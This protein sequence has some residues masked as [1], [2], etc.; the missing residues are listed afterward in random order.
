MEELISLCCAACIAGGFGDP[1]AVP[2]EEPGL[3]WHGL[4]ASTLTFR[5]EAPES[6]APAD[7]FHLQEARLGLA[8]APMRGVG[9]YTSIAA[10]QGGLG[11]IEAY[12][13]LKPLK[14]FG[15]RVGHWIQPVGP[16]SG[17]RVEQRCFADSPL[18]TERFLG[19]DGLFDTGLEL[20]YAIPIESFPIL[21]SASVLRGQ[22]GRSFGSPAEAGEGGDAFKRLLYLVRVVANPGKLWGGHLTAGFLFGTGLN[23][24]GPANRTDIVGGNLSGAFRAGEVT[25]G[26]DLEYLMRRYS[27]PR[28]LHV[29][30]GLSADVVADYRGW[31]G[32]LRLD[33]LG[34]PTPPSRDELQW[35]FAVAAGYS[36]TPLTR[37]RVQ[38]AARDDNLAGALGHE[39]LFQAILGLDGTLAG[40]R[41]TAEGTTTERPRDPGV[42]PKDTK[43]PIRVEPAP[44]LTRVD[45]PQLAPKVVESQNPKD[46]L[47]AAQSDLETAEAMTRAG[48][49]GGSA[50]HAQQAA[51]NALKAVALMR[52]APFAPADR[53]AIGAVEALAR[54]GEPPPGEI[55][56]AARE[57][58][59]HYTLSRYPPELGGPPARY[60]DRATAT[61]ARALA[62]RILSWARTQLTP[63]G[64]SEAPQIQPAPSTP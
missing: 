31:H 21:V 1:A 27:I 24:T 33:V 60:Y 17:R 41:Q 46:W 8:G 3:G 34:L 53:S 30:G 50:F 35:R 42:R 37:F 4:G 26:V 10:N 36:L 19:P 16:I 18:A 57:L 45:P 62:E 55:W 29:E 6:P 11:N 44:P 12:G 5:G 40:A 51:H 59:R 15:I 54:D 63:P 47:T 14:G 48:R 58:D 61:R 28:A 38:Y 39:V 20:S 13:D 22:S 32:G 43:Q 2:S 25:I 23:D 49:H 56:T 52:G 9:L 64:P 7:G